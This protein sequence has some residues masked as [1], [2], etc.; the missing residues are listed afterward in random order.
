M[1]PCKEECDW[2]EELDSFKVDVVSTI[3][4]LKAEIRRVNERIDEDTTTNTK[5]F[6]SI[7]EDLGHIKGA[8]DAKRMEVEQINETVQKEKKE[9][10]Q[11]Q[12]D[13]RKLNEKILFVFIGALA[14]GLVA[15]AVHLATKII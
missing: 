3:G 12:F 5:R 6:I 11:L 13:S 4:D 15:L 14:S 2:K 8:V 1:E 9:R 10:K 7:A